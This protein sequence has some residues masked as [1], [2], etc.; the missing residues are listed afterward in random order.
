MVVGGLVSVAVIWPESADWVLAFVLGP[1]S[2]APTVVSRDVHTGRLPGLGS[3]L[4]GAGRADAGHEAAFAKWLGA[5]GQ[6]EQLGAGGGHQD[7]AAGTEPLR[8]VAETP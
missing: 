1:M 5:G 8:R 2:A 6:V 4:G 3:V 7:G